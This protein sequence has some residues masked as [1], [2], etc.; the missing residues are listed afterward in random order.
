MNQWLP[1]TQH[2]PKSQFFWTSQSPELRFGSWW[3]QCGQH[4]VRA[5]MEFGGCCVSHDGMMTSWL[6]VVDRVYEWWFIMVTVINESWLIMNYTGSWCLIDAWSNLGFVWIWREHPW[7][8]MKRVG[9]PCDS[10]V[11]LCLTYQRS[12][13]LSNIFTFPTQWKNKTASTCPK[14]GPKVISGQSTSFFLFK[15]I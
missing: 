12:S 14:K 9:D 8:V 5:T 4:H 1:I 6:I 11:L 10:G 13:G 15:N 3:S 7:N 2:H